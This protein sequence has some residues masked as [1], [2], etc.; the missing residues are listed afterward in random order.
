MITVPAV[1]TIFNTDHENKPIPESVDFDDLPI[2]YHG[3]F[4]SVDAAKDWMYNVYPDD[5]DDIEDQFYGEFEVEVEWL[6]DP[7]SLFGEAK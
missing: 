4:D 2:V 5:C 7:D 6:N 3:P 1:K